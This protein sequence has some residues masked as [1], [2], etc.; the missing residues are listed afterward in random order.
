VISYGDLATARTIPATTHGRYLIE[1]PASHSAAPLLIG[2]HG[3]AEA[4]EAQLDRLRAIPGSRDWLLVSVQA[5]HPFYRGRSEDVVA[6]WMTRQDRELAIADN[7]AYVNMVV[8]SIAREWAL[9][10]TLVFAGFSQGVAMAFRAAASSRRPVA[11]VIACG[12]D[13][14]PELDAA[15]L[16][17]VRAAIVGRGLRDPWYTSDKADADA[18]RLHGA[19]VRLRPVEFDGGHEW[20]TSFAG[21]AGMFLNEC[22]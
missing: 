19:G 7:T 15:S 16:A 2:F 21:A 11:G 8:E 5:L 14:P 9:T 17:R 18:Q 12:G 13:V 6:G 10:P 4:A 22:R 20:S 3:Y 1:A